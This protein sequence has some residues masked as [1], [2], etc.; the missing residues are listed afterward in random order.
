MRISRTILLWLVVIVALL[1]LEVAQVTRLFT[2]GF[3]SILGNVVSFVFALLL[4]T[5]LALVG[6]IFVGI[7]IAHRILAPQGFSPFEEEMLK[8]RQEV[9]DLHRKLDRL[10]VPDGAPSPLTGEAAEAPVHAR[11][12][13][14]S[15]TAQ[16]GPSVKERP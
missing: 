9:Q 5:I 8:M 13:S 11:P 14:P 3:A 16:S 6:A 1:L 12:Q 10:S 4:V 15:S 7:F 2:L